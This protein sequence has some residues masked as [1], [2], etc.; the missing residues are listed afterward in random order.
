MTF[1]HSCGTLG[2]LRSSY[3][4]DRCGDF[5]SIIK[6]GELVLPWTIL[7]HMLLDILHQIAEAFA[8]VIPCAFVVD[9]A[10]DPLDGVGPRTV[11]W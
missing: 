8:L 1:I 7:F 3:V 5:R 11:R 2:L 4:L 6:M 9:I 10:K